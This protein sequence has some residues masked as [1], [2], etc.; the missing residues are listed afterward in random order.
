MPGRLTLAGYSVVY[1]MQAEDI[2]KTRLVVLKTRSAY[3]D[4]W[5]MV[6]REPKCNVNFAHQPIV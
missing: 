1:S 5:R 2:E 4:C 6:G 3:C